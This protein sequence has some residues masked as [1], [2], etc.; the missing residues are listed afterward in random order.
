[1][2]VGRKGYNEVFCC[3]DARLLN[4]YCNLREDRNSRLVCLKSGL[5]KN[6]LGQPNQVKRYPIMVISF[7]TIVV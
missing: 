1:M 7:D 6:V 3:Y 2:K 5:W 4:C